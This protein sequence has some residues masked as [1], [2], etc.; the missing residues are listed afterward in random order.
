M[1]RSSK[2]EDVVGCVWDCVRGGE[3]VVIVG[4]PGVGKTVALYVSLLDMF[5]KRGVNVGVL[6]YGGRVGRV[7]EEEGFVLFLDDAPKSRSVLEAIYH[8]SVRYIVATGRSVDWRELS[9]RLREPF[10]VV[11][12][13]PLDREELGE[14]LD[15][16]ASHFGVVVDEDARDIIVDRCRGS[17]IYIRYLFEDAVRKGVRRIDR[18]FVSGVPRGMYDYV[19]SIIGDIFYEGD[20]RRDG[21]YGVC[22]TLRILGD[23]RDYRVSE[24][25]LDKIYDLSSDLARRVFGDVV[26]FD[27]YLRMKDFLARD[28]E[29]GSI[30]FPHDIWADIVVRKDTSHRVAKFISFV[31]SKVPYKRRARIIRDAFRSVFG[32]VEDEFKVFGDKV[33]KDRISVA[34]YAKLNRDLIGELSEEEVVRR[35]AEEYSDL[36]ISRIYL[37]TAP[38]P[39]RKEPLI[40]LTVGDQEY[41][42]RA[43]EFEVGRNPHGP[44]VQIRY[45]DQIIDT[46]I[47]DMTVSKKHLKVFVEGKKIY[48]MDLGSRNGTWVDSRKLEPN[49]KYVVSEVRIGGYGLRVKIGAK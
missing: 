28:P 25:V 14:L 39:S 30:G 38:R 35:E 27:L 48:V 6:Q 23:L 18:D 1:Y 34:Y 15:R 37:M 45:G 13:E 43:F 49:K 8:N 10:R 29:L 22:L 5:Y 16:Y 20:R 47:L 26:N 3:N 33:A 41:R 11:V 24:R 19:A 9:D 42:F 32:D 31:E 46:P 2:L 44:N 7:H 17:P 4:D 36:T 40:L 12:L 21:A